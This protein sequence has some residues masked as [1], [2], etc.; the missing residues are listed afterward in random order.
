MLLQT[1]VCIHLFQLV[2][3]LF[4]GYISRT[5]IARSYDSFLLLLFFK[6]LYIVFH[7]GCTDLH[8]HPQCIRISFSP[9]LLQHLLFLSFFFLTMQC[10]MWGLR[11][12]TRDQPQTSYNGSMQSTSEP[13]GESLFV[14]FL[15]F[16]ILAD[17]SWYLMVVLIFISLILV[18]GNFPCSP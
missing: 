2:F 14:D 12:L 10:S 17:V 16:I 6:N 11:S 13:P 8:S 4:F 15:M 1:L 5:G 7:R 9:H 18:I 3:L